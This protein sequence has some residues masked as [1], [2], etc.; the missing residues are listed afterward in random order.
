[1][2]VWIEIVYGWRMIA[3]GIVT[4]YMGVWIEILVLMVIGIG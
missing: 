3:L 2:G 1:M 4:P